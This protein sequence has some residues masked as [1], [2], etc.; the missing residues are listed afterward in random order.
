MVNILTSIASVT[1]KQ[2]GT[3]AH[4]D[5]FTGVDYLENMINVFG[6][7][8]YA[9]YKITRAQSYTRHKYA[10]VHKEYDGPEDNRLGYCMTIEQCIEE[11]DEKNE[12]DKPEAKIVLSDSDKLK[13]AVQCIEANMEEFKY[14]TTEPNISAERHA[15][16]TH[17]IELCAN[18]LKAIQE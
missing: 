7:I 18:A 12:D 4:P 16:F 17:N 9:E 10:Y 1:K 13:I 14:R 11:I 3:Y 2:I 6:E 5:G 8:E 15:V